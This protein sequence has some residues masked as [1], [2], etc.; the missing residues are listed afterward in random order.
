MSI[1][2]DSR[3]LLPIKKVMPRKAKKE[4]T[5]LTEQEIDAFFRAIRDPRDKAMFRFMYHQPDRELRLAAEA[6]RT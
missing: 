4:P 2:C 5:Y 3:T 1:L 6:V